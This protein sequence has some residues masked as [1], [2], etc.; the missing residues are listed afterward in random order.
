MCDPVT[1][2][3]A[4]TAVATMGTVF[5]GYVA[6][7]QDAYAAGIASNNAV[8][9]QRAAVAAQT[10][11][12]RESVAQGEQLSSLKGQQIAAMAA[13]GVDLSSG[14]PLDVQSASAVLG[15]Q[16]AQTTR[17]NTAMRVQGFQ[18]DSANY[19]AESAADHAKIGSDW[20]SAGLGATS[21]ILG[22]ASSAMGAAQKYG[23]PSWMGGGSSGASGYGGASLSGGGNFGAGLH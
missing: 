19:T 15:A 21:T 2:T 16:D 20:V 8:Y 22:G 13:N 23:T 3:I 4:A 5:S 12:D 14:S 11:G 10:A 6:A 9:A 7:K 18:I 1:L 17:D